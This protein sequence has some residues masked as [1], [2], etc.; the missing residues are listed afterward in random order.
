MTRVYLIRHGRPSS[1]WGGDD[2]DPGLD[3][4]G[5]AQARAVAERFMSMPVADRPSRVV[6]S[7]LRR[8]RETAE[9]TARALDLPLEIDPM[10]GEIPTPVGLSDAE[11]PAWLHA[12]FRGTWADIVGDLDYDQW[13]HDIASALRTYPG[14]AVFSHFVAINGVVSS[15]EGDP[16]VIAFR[17]DHT[18]TSAFDVT[19]RGL[20]LVRRGAEAATGVV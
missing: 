10:F 4:A 7:P 18:S 12:A 19:A 13:R 14:A 8:C 11:R 17:P 20:T 5:H 16:N 3:T 15:L 6:S 1:S 2:L 9:P